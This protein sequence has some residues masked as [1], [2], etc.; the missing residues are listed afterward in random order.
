MPSRDPHH[1]SHHET[2]RSRVSQRTSEAGEWWFVRVRRAA[3]L[4]ACCAKWL[5]TPCRSVAPTLAVD[6]YGCREAHNS[7]IEPDRH[8]SVCGA[9][10]HTA[11]LN[12]NLT[13]ED[14]QALECHAPRLRSWSNR[15]VVRRVMYRQGD[16][17]LIQIDPTELPTRA[18]RLDPDDHGRL[19]LVRGER[20]GH[21]HAVATRGAELFAD[22]DSLDRS[23]LVLAS[24]AQLTHEEHAP[25]PLPAGSYRVV[26][27][28][29][30]TSSA[31]K[32]VVD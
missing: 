6:W 20:T 5:S 26:R 16:V 18:A 12:G 29:E 25:V 30:Y 7:S 14:F 9:D 19:V 28:R 24:E 31:L 22:P 10:P 17:L 11:Q 13:T 2:S 4:R 8:D 21:V 23:F 32:D 3:L 15:Y 27:Q 1:S